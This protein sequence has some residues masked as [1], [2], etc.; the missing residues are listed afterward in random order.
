MGSRQLLHF[1]ILI[2]KARSIGLGFD[3][4]IWIRF[5]FLYLSFIGQTSK[6]HSS[7]VVVLVI[8]DNRMQVRTD[9]QAAREQCFGILV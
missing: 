7:I 9:Q 2:S 6:T 4:E 3:S 1:V 8:T 5:K